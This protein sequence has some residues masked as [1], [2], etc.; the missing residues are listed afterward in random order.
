[1][2]AA[3]AAG[4]SSAIAR[5]AVGRADHGAKVPSLS[6]AAGAVSSDL[7]SAIRYAQSKDSWCRGRR[8]ARRCNGDT[9]GRA[10]QRARVVAVC[11]AAPRRQRVGRLPATP[12]PETVVSSA[13]MNIIVPS[14]SADPSYRLSDGTS[15]A[16]AIHLRRGGLIRCAVPEP[17]RRR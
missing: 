6:L 9:A 16:T 13:A 15:Q 8:A 17:G 1:V 10:R 11:P 4:P 12:G 7:L 3:K 14:P 5:A 2:L